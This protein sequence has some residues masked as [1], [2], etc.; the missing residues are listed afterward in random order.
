VKARARGGRW[1][2]ASGRGDSKRRRVWLFDLDD[3]LHDATHAAFEPINR[4]MTAFVARELGIDQEAAGSLRHRYWQRYGATLLGLI[5]HHGV[6]PQR[7]LEQTHRLEGLE[8]RLRSPWGDR[9]VLA[10]LP[11]RKIVLTNAPAA[12]A[13]R[14]LR[15]LDLGRYFDAV[16][17]IEGMRM[18]GH[19]RPKPDR[20][21]LRHV[22]ARMKAD[23]RRCVLVDDTRVHLRAARAVGMHAVWMQ[24]YTR[25]AK[26][27]TTPREVGAHPCCKPHGV[28]ARIRALRQLMDL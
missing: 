19:W 23:P 17:P 2:D 10:R 27:I 12:Y 15:T 4:A 24:R 26:D 1:E 13:E 16:V 9:R 22:C 8:D 25:S 11:G 5:R 21:M 14:V 28:Y 3:T 20:R 7:F 6:D 18:F